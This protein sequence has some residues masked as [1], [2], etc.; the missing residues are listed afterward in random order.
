MRIPYTWKKKGRK[1]ENF[2]RMVENIG[3]GVIA[4]GE[5]MEDKGGECRWAFGRG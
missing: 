4:E 5:E 2:R 3:K 1:K